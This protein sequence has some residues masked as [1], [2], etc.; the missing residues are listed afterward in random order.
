MEQIKL[1]IARDFSSAPG[2][3]YIHE[4]ERSGEK[5]RK[6]ILFPLLTKAITEGKKLFVD[7]DGTAGY[8]TSF[9]EESFGGLIREEHIEYNLIKKHIEL[10]SI[11]EPYLLEDIESYLL[12]ASKQPSHTA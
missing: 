9:L 6:E 2:P 4:G 10:K 8:G 1:I 5:F 11:E 12:D 7:L 3:R